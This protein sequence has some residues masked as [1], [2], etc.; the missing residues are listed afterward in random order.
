VYD[1]NCLLEEGAEK[2]GGVG[3][4]PAD[5]FLMKTSGSLV[6]GTRRGVGEANQFSN[7][8]HEFFLSFVFRLSLKELRAPKEA[9]SLRITAG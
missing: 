6:I 2:I 1:V 5:L 7:D 3:A 8:C 4:S 9:L